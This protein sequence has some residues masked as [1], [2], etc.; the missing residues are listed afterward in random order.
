[1]SRQVP[2]FP[3]KARLDLLGTLQL[4]AKPTFPLKLMLDN[5]AVVM[6]DGELAEGGEKEEVRAERTC[7]VVR[8]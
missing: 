4:R 6:Q 2:R 7:A 1:M 3:A 8:G 5:L